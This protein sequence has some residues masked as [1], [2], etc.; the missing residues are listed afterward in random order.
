MIFKLFKKLFKNKNLI[1]MEILELSKELEIDNNNSKF[2]FNRGV[3]YLKM[4]NPEDALVNFILASKI[5]KNLTKKCQ[6]LCGK[7]HPLLLEKFTSAMF[8]QINTN[9]I[10]P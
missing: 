6:Y 10:Y 8:Y 1:E 9:T 2:L 5:D 7:Y 3:L 4:K